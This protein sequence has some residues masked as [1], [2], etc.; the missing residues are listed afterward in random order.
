MS[1]SVEAGG[2]NVPLLAALGWLDG[3][4]RI[5]TFLPS[6]RA[7]PVGDVRGM[8]LERCEVLSLRPCERAAMLA[9][10]SGTRRNVY[11]QVRRVEHVA[12]QG[13]AKIQ[14]VVVPEVSTESPAVLPKEVGEA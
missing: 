8:E 13:L 7:L 3:L 9:P 14:T 1:F 10:H 4:G 2:I 5:G 6:L 11:R 12:A